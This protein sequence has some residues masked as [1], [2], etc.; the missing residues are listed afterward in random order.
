MEIERIISFK[1]L[2]EAI[3]YTCYK[4]RPFHYVYMTITLVEGK[5]DMLKWVWIVCMQ[6]HLIILYYRNRIEKYW[7]YTLFTTSRKTVWI[8]I[9]QT[10]FLIFFSPQKGFNTF[11]HHELFETLFAVP[12]FCC[13]L[14]PQG[15]QKYLLNMSKY[16]LGFWICSN[17]Y[18][19]LRSLQKSQSSPFFFNF[20]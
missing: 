5:G 19:S 3:W 9:C 1:L 20:N 10:Y 15:H 18:Q 8:F 6:A 14:S 12:Y 7:L 17:V 16:I 2:R 11:E 4:H 13:K